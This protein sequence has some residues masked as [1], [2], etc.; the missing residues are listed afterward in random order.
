MLALLFALSA[1]AAQVDV[2]PKEFPVIV[3]CFFNERVVSKV[4]SPLFAKALVMETGPKDGVAGSTNG[5]ARDTA[6]KDTVA[7]V[8]VDSCMMPRELIDEAKQLASLRTGIAVDRMLVAATHTHSAPAAMPCL[9]SD[10]QPGY[11]QFLAGKI[12][13]AI[14]TAHSR[15]APAKFGATVVDAPAHTFNRR[16]IY[17]GDKRLTSPFAERNVWA[18]MHPGYQNPDALGPSGPVDT[19]LTLLSVQHADGRPMALLANYSMHYFLSEPLSSDYYGVFAEQFTAAIGAGPDFVAM[20]SQGT[21]GDLMWMNYAGAKRDYTIAAFTAGLV[22]RAVEGYRSIRHGSPQRALQAKEERMTLQRRVPDAQRLAWAREMMAKLQ[23]RKPKT[24]PEIYAREQIYLHEEPQRELKLQ[25]YLLGDLA[26]T[27][28]PNEVFAIT[29]LKL[30]SRSPARLTMNLELAN[31]AEGY[32]PPPEQH[33]LGGYTTWAA[34]TAGLQVEAEPR[35]TAALLRMLEELTGEPSRKELWNRGSYAREVMALSPW[36]HWPMENMDGESVVGHGP[37][38]KLEGPRALYLQGLEGKAVQLVGGR[39]VLPTLPEGEAW[40]V[41]AWQWRGL[42]WDQL[43]HSPVSGPDANREAATGG[44]RHYAAVCQKQ[45]NA[46]TATVY[47]DGVAQSAGNCHQAI[48]QVVPSAMEG[49]LDEVSAFTRALAEG[50][51][52]RLARL[53]WAPAPQNTATTTVAAKP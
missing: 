48:E 21:S 9:G 27:A 19:G 50:E 26:L 5:P 33:L 8:V 43:G 30:K 37:A 36:A 2:T 4:T 28:L 16:F 18:N 40:S 17:K 11:A 22:E 13:E 42:P 1:G 39:L 35:I 53:P 10:A 45:G 47:V 25:T 29:G 23:G 15:L 38:A 49:K 6:A 51:V 24:Q 41:M 52:K 12:A 3:N 46:I 34:R 32:I 31:G 20:L 7:L 14:T 44:W